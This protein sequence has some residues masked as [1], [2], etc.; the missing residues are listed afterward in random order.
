MT[1]MFD[2][3]KVAKGEGYSVFGDEFYIDALLLSLCT[4]CYRVQQ[5]LDD[6]AWHLPVYAPFGDGGSNKCIGFDFYM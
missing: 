2:K 3:D 4:N 1:Q 5:E 6:Y